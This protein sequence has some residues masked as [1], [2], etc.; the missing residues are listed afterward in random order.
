MRHFHEHFD[1]GLDSV[2]FD[3]DRGLGRVVIRGMPH[4][5]P[6]RAC[7]EGQALSPYH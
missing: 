4:K 3:V 5:Y 2:R 7:Y 6:T 1:A